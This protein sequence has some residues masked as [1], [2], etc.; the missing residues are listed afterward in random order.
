MFSSRATSIS[1][2]LPVTV[3]VPQQLRRR[4]RLELRPPSAPRHDHVA[5]FSFARGP[6]QRAALDLLR[7]L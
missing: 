4:L 6:T 2:A 5:V 7:Q 1:T 3:S